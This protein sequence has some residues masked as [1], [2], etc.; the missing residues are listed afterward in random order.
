MHVA[1]ASERPDL[2]PSRL[3]LG[4]DCRC[5]S[6]DL[7]R[8]PVQVAKEPGDKSDEAASRT[9]GWPRDDRL[10]AWSHQQMTGGEANRTKRETVGQEQEPTEAGDQDP[11][12]RTPQPDGPMVQRTEP[13]GSSEEMGANPDREYGQ[14]GR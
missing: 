6:W 7:Y 8:P 1:I 5:W 10:A 4:P 11:A 13:P 2:S 12:K 3:Q 9:P 14:Q